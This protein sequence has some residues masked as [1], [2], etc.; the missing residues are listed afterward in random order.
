MVKSRAKAAVR[1]WIR[2]IRYINWLTMPP[3]RQLLLSSD[4]AA[5]SRNALGNLEACGLCHL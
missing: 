4:L 1:H 3:V 5:N 2:R